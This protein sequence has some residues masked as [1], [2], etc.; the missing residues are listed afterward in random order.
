MGAKGTRKGKRG[1]I[2]YFYN[3]VSQALGALKNST[4]AA[5]NTVKKVVRNSINGVN[6]VGRKVSGRANAAIKGLIPKRFT[7]RRR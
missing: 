2:R 1:L 6:T 3:P 7:R 5:T 4:S